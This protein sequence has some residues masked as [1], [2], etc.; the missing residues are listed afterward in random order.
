MKQE[1]RNMA[2][3]DKDKQAKD[4]YTDISHQHPRIF[5]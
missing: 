5:F 4:Y 2:E 3:Y 1:K